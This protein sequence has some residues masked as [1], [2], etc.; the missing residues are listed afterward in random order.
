MTVNIIDYSA[1]I[2]RNLPKGYIPSRAIG[3]NK[4]IGA[5]PTDIW[6]GGRAGGSNIKD[7]EGFI[8]VPEKFVLTGDVNDVVDGSGA[9]LVFV[10][11]LNHLG[12]M[13]SEYIVPTGT[14]PVESE[15]TYYRVNEAV[16][17]VAG[18]LR[19]NSG[20]I[21]IKGA[22]SDV[23]FA[24][25]DPLNVAALMAIKTVPANYKG[26]IVKWKGSLNNKQSGAVDMFLLCNDPIYDKKVFCIID[27]VGLTTSGKSS[28]NEEFDF[29]IPLEPLTDVK[30]RAGEHIGLNLSASAGL[31]LLLIKLKTVALIGG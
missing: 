13:D 21:E 19:A 4:D 27:E 8:T 22:D 14:D 3:E 30:A 11:G 10:S 1:V 26:F 31:G 24:E 9:R 2:A 18:S 7:Y 17:K 15:K 5:N 29:P 6:C 20:H 16:V 25:I 28:F 12:L 23:T